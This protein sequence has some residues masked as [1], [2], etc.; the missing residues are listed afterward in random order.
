MSVS[1]PS[2]V[3]AQGSNETQAYHC[4]VNE[5]KILD[6]AIEMNQV[7]LHAVGYNY[8]IVDDCWSLYGEREKYDPER[9]SSA[10]RLIPDPQ[11]FPHGMKSLGDRLHSMGYK[12]G[13]YSSAGEITCA[14][15]PGSLYFEEIDAQ[16][17]ASWGVD[18]E[19]P[20]EFYRGF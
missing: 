8:V 12:F 13:I 14:G 15:Y 9:N 4:D 16:T 19:F 17:F 7:G 11:R 6:A 20:I 18:C 3:G 10:L 1:R 2:Q 5:G